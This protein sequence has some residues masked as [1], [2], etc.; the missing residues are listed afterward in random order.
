LS[1]LL[2][3]GRAIVRLANCDDYHPRWR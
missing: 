3:C 1:I 2:D